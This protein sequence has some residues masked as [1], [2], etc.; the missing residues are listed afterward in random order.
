MLQKIEEVHPPFFT[1]FVTVNTTPDNQ[2]RS[3]LNDDFFFLLERRSVSNVDYCCRDFLRKVCDLVVL[4]STSN[5]CRSDLIS[6]IIIH[7]IYWII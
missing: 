6:G 7:F 5:Q 4:A 2:T 1:L 3:E